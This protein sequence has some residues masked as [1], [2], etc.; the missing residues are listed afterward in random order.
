MDLLQAI[1]HLFRD[2]TQKGSTHSKDDEI[3]P[4]AQQGTGEIARFTLF[5]GQEQ[6]NGPHETS[7]VRLRPPPPGRPELA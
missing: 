3:R 4:G 1:F 6:V 2:H 5:L 7:S